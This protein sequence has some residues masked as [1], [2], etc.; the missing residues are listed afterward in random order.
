MTPVVVAMEENVTPTIIPN[1]NS[2][3]YRRERWSSNV[4]YTTSY[5]DESTDENEAIETYA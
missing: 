4:R 1:I 2:Y 3:V 5:R